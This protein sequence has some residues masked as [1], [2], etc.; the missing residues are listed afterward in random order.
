MRYDVCHD[1]EVKLPESQGFNEA[2]LTE[3][4]SGDLKRVENLRGPVPHVGSGERG[5]VR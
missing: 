4:L 3:D 5:A 2:N 1:W